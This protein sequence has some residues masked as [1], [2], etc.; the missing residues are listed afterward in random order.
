VL[1]TEFTVGAVDI[2]RKKVE[3]LYTRYNEVADKAND[4]MTAENL[5]GQI[6]EAEE[7]LHE[8]ENSDN[9]DIKKSKTYK[10]RLTAQRSVDLEKKL[11]KSVLSVL[12]D[13]APDGIDANGGTSQ[14][15]SISMPLV[16]DIVM[17][18]HASLQKFQHDIDIDKAYDIYDEYIDA[19]GSYMDFF[20]I[21]RNVLEVSGFLP[22][23]AK[24]KAE[25]K[26]GS[27]PEA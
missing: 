24:A 12:M 4:K 23:K 27:N 11:G 10:L 21:L 2:Q 26:Q 25:A 16:G 3:A 15:K 8:L 18:L 9:P 7:N 22:K 19:G 14:L 6:N 1:Y 20:E 17:I 13:M 5:A